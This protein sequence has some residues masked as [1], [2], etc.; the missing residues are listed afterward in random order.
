MRIPFFRIWYSSWYTVLFLILVVLLCVSPG[1]LV[2]QAIRNHSY[3]NAFVVGGVYLLTLVIV[4]FV[5]SSRL[6]TNKTVLAAIPKSYIPVESGEV[7]KNVRRMIVKGFERS[8]LIAWDSRPRDLRS[9]QVGDSVERLSSPDQ[10]P[11]ATSKT[12]K[13]DDATVIP[14]NPAAPPWGHISHPG[15]SSPSADSLPN[16]QFRTVVAE[17]PNLIE[18]KAVSLAPPDPAFAFP[19]L[20]EGQV[21]PDARIVSLLQRPSSMGLR[22]YI[23]HL[24]TF[25][26][27]NPPQ[28]GAAFLARYEYARFSTDALGEAQFQELMDLFAQLLSGMMEL[29][30]QLVADLHREVE[31]SPTNSDSVS[32]ASWQSSS[33]T[34][35][36]TGSAIHY[37]TPRTGPYTES[38]YT[39]STTSTAEG[40]IGGGT[41]RTA[42][43]HMPDRR[44]SE[45]VSSMRSPRTPTAESF[46]SAPAFR[47]TPIMQPRRQGS[48]D[49]ARSI[50][51]S[52]S[53]ARSVIRLNHN[54]RPGELPY[55]YQQEDG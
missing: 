41:M 49:P 39:R 19:N 23:A 38:V 55:F 37:K 18:A 30:P 7:G 42:P 2:Y 16:L 43:S 4:G 24:S 45:T 11:P 29:S 54:P 9:E 17:L 5:Y 53:S 40:S 10:S 44:P 1:D 14:I 27:V 32:L 13:L 26:L 50:S 51:S 34:G 46:A 15:W 36:S 31:Y 6:Y 20:P 25:G 35:N 12:D 52:S 3:P 8:A 33:S 47:S 48:I 28:V 21:I 22:D